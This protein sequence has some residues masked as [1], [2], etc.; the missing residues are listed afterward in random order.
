M[1]TTTSAAPPVPTAR[2]RWWRRRS[3]LLLVTALLLAVVVAIILGSGARTTA[4]LD[5]DNPDPNGARAIARVLD[6]HG[7][8]VSVA[9]DADALDNAAIDSDTTVLVTSSE[10]LGESTIDRLLGD[11]R[12]ATLVVVEPG[13]GAVEAMGAHQLPFEVTLDG[14][15]PADCADPTYDGLSLD[16]DQALEY[17]TQGGCFRGNH[18]ALLADIGPG[19]TVFGAGDALSN[20]QILRADNAAVAL[21]LLGQHDRLVWYVPTVDDLVGSDGVSL[22]T[23]LPEWLR[24]TLWLLLIAAVAL[25]VWRARRLGSLSTEPLPV[26]V[27]AIETTRSRGRLYRKS[28]DRA[29]AAEALRRAAATQAAERLGL[30][31]HPDPLVLVRET[32]RQTGRPIEEIDALLGPGTRPPTTDQDLINLATRLAE[33]DREVRRT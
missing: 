21:R 6:H 3:A 13:P 33:L 4:D 8:D 22:S 18:G 26:V 12:G 14:P 7:V 24:P 10:M 23:L 32:A 17:P 5:P 9:R 15:R 19:V 31:A 2:P 27:K 25:I 28:G 1:T 16:V 30:G 11:A 20:D 29:H